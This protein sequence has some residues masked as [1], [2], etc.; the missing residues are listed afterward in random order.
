MLPNCFRRFVHEALLKACAAVAATT[1]GRVAADV[2]PAVLA[3]QLN[4]LSTCAQLDGRLFVLCS[5]TAASPAARE[6]AIQKSKYCGASAAGLSSLDVDISVESLLALLDS[7]V[8]VSTNWSSVII[9]PRITA[10][11]EVFEGILR[12]LTLLFEHSGANAVVPSLSASVGGVVSRLYCAVLDDPERSTS[13]R[14]PILRAL[15]KILQ[16]ISA[17]SKLH[18][19]AVFRSAASALPSSSMLARL[20]TIAAA[21]SFDPSSGDFTGSASAPNE[22]TQCGTAVISAVRGSG[23]TPAWVPVLFGV[24]PSCSALCVGDTDSR[25]PQ[26]RLALMK[27]SLRAAMVWRAYFVLLH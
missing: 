20:F 25:A 11:G 18:M 21:I 24:T 17:T 10:C 15:Y 23:S 7:A 1:S 16:C 5:P 6:A 27:E 2:L 19:N 9:T 22:L 12:T 3:S 14:S 4:V 8:S 26:R 13:S